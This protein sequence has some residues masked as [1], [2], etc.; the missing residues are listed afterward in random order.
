M[1]LSNA[2]VTKNEPKAAQWEGPIYP[3]IKMALE[4]FPAEQSLLI[5]VTALTLDENGVPSSERD[6]ILRKMKESE[7]VYEALKIL[8][9]YVS[10]V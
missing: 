10:F 1:P 3:H 2:T 5:Y 8:A 7:D 6:P 4:G 9:R